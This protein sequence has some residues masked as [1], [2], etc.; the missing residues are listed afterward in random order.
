MTIKQV[1]IYCALCTFAS[2]AATRY[3]FPS[4]Q[5]KT[6]V[7]EKEVIHNDIQTV[8]KVVKMPSGETDTIT[9]VIDHTQKTETNT[10][11][12]IQLNP[13]NWIVSGTV[14]TDYHFLPYYGAQVQRRIL[15]P[16][17]VGALLN[18]RGEVGLSLGFEF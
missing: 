11:L 13:K 3:Y 6:V 7:T 2:A 18:T 1:L 15:G 4:I 5:T 14:Q 9:T 12:S 8:T 16:I 17:L 10:Q